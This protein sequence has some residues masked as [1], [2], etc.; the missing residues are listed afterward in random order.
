MHKGSQSTRVF[1]LE[2][3]IYTTNQI[4]N[5]WL[6]EANPHT[7]TSL[8]I[9]LVRFAGYLQLSAKYKSAREQRGFED[10]NYFD[11]GVENE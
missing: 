2:Q 5:L 8:S 7:H 9:L 6:K 10:R 4:G 3:P 1:A 11:K